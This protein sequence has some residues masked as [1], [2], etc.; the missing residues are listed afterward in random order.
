MAEL[1]KFFLEGLASVMAPC[2]LPL[3]PTYLAA[4][5][6]VDGEHLGERR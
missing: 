1:P 4:I 6:A 2:V 3:L 5:A